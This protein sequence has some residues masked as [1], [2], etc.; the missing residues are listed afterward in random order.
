MSLTTYA[1]HNVST[2]GTDSIISSRRTSAEIAL[3]KLLENDNIHL[4]QS[5]IQSMMATLLL[6]F[7]LPETKIV[8]SSDINSAERE[9][10]NAINN[11]RRRREEERRQRD[12]DRQRR[13]Q[14]EEVRL[15]RTRYRRKSEED[16]PNENVQ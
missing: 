15:T 16:N 6:V 7:E 12:R 9:D 10:L 13:S 8:S 1:Q 14:R 3:K 4:I 11:T 5:D 2:S